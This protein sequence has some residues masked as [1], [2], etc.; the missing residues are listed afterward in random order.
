MSDD[1][2]TELLAYAQ[3]HSLPWVEDE[4]NADDAYPRNFLRHRVLPSLA[5]RFPAYRTTLSRSARHFAEASDLLEQL[6][7]QDGSGAIHD[8]RLDLARLRQLDPT[9]A[10][11][12]LR[13]F[14]TARGAIPDST[15]LDETLRQLYQAG[16][17]AAVCIDYAGWQIRCYHDQVFVLPRLP[18]LNPQLSVRWNREAALPLPALG[19]TLY[20]DT[21]PGQGL[22]L[23]KLQQHEVTVR[24]RR[25]G[26]RIRLHA[27]RPVKTLKNLFQEHNIPPW[28]RDRL[29]LLFCGDRLVA[30]PGIGIDCAC[31][32]APAEPGR[33]PRWENNSHTE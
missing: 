13:S 8:D 5:Q 16:P 17:D 26:E 33:L 2:R 30:I 21:A 9:R 24:L 20:F 12:L 15:R 7:Q 14:I 3:Q 29:P 25:G 28:Q 6:A 18:E 32:A 22:S 10:K 1:D 27:R 23:E 4:S 19:G 11:N 31:Q